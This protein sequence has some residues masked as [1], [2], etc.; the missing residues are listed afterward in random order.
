MWSDDGVEWTDEEIEAS[1]FGIGFGK[2][3]GTNTVTQVQI[4]KWMEEAGQE[5]WGLAKDVANRPYQSYQGQRVAGLAPESQQVA[6]AVRRM[7]GT[8]AQQIADARALTQ[9]A[10][11]YNPMQVG[12]DYQPQQVQSQSLLSGDV[13]AYMN[14]FTQQVINNSL[15]TLDQQ[16]RQALA[17]TG[18][19]ARS[20]GAFGGSR[21]GVMEGVV[22]TQSAQAAGELA[23]KLQA[24]NYTQAVANIQADQTRAQQAAIANQ[25][26]GLEA[27]SQNLSAQSANQQAGLTSAQMRMQAGAQLGSLAGAQ[28]DLTGREL[29]L[30][31][32]VGQ[33]GREL[34][35]ANLDVAYQNWLDQYNYPIQQ[36]G[37]RN[38]ALGMQPYSQ[39]QTSSSSGSPGNVAGGALGG[40]AA[41]AGIA[42]AIGAS[43]GWGAGLGALAGAYSASDPRLKTD[44]EHVGEDPETGLGVYA[45]RYKGD[46]KNYPKVLGLMADE[47]AEEAPEA[48]VALGGILG[49][50]PRKIDASAVV[51]RGL[52]DAEPDA[53]KP[54]KAKKKKGRG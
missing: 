3:G 4:P 18:D 11:G 24:D 42:S 19:Q 20:A 17:Q 16:R 14:P 15:N 29:T 51:S 52:L 23:A 53:P 32:T 12:S 36:L 34:N 47:V 43:G 38:T 35:Q 50:D 31:D 7:Q 22:N 46:P 10:A 41:G 26:A 25:Q 28:S 44:V 6:Q 8:G 49:F 13:G 54:P 48:S 21:H 2:G 5:N 27:N 9:S 37:I 40:A 39:T 45:Y 30:L 1:R 33:Q